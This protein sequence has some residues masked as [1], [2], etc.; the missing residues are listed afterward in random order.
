MANTYLAYPDLDI[1]KFCD[2]DRDQDAES[3][4]DL[5][6][7]KIKFAPGDAPADV[8]V[9]ANYTFRKKELFSYLLRGQSDEWYENNITNAN[10]RENVGTNLITR[11]SDGRNKFPYRMEVKTCVRGDGEEIRNFLHRI[12]RTADKGWPDDIEKIAPADHGAK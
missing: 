9:L 1:D 4:I 11:F 5:M 6:E 2:T 10:A 8:G 12:K 7:R 3:F